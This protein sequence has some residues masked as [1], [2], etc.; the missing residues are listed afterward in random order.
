VYRLALRRAPLWACAYHH[1]TATLAGEEAIVGRRSS[2]RIDQTAAVSCRA[3][4]EVEHSAAVSGGGRSGCDRK[5]EHGVGVRWRQNE[6]T[7]WRSCEHLFLL[8]R[9]NN[10]PCRRAREAATGETVAVCGR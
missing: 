4:Q 3:V 5:T 1:Q 7:R 8:A 9:I 6:Q 10:A 2:A